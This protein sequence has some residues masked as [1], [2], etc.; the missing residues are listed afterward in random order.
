MAMDKLRS[1]EL[2]LSA[3]DQ[4]SYAAAAIKC[5]TSPSTISKAISRL[6]EIAVTAFTG[7]GEQ[8][9]AVF[10]VTVAE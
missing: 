3:I 5:E 4:G 7:D 6:N 2:F 8:A 1:L 10:T 9:S